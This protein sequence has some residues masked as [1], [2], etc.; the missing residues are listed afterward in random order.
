[1]KKHLFLTL[2]FL[3][4]CVSILPALPQEQG[5]AAL[6]EIQ[7]EKDIIKTI[8]RAPHYGVFDSL[9]FKLDGNNVT[10]MGQAMLPITKDEVGKRVAKLTGIGKVT[11]AIVVLP[12]SHT[13]DIIRM[14]VY[15]SLFGTADLYRY[16]LGPNPSIHIIVDKGH[17]TLEGMV[18]TAGDS[19][20]AELGAR[21][22][23]GVFSLT[24]HLQVEK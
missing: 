19:R 20:F 7:L 8:T 22:V 21:K 14:R 2:L 24:N 10:L 6:P 16:A 9:S 3:A 23:G 4:F 1:M 5:M 12:L 15:R 17:V 11:N 13:D 18:S